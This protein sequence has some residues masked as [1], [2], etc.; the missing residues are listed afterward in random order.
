[1]ALNS[2]VKLGPY[3]IQTPLG[4]GGMGEVYRA[5]D[6]RLDRTVA[7]KILAAQHSSSPELKQRMEREARAISSLN[8]PN[9]CHLYDIGSQDGTDFL[10]MEFLEG[11]TLAERLRA[12]ALALPEVYKI[13]IAVAEA[14]AFA[15]RNG[16]LHRDLKPG[17]IMLTA[18]GAK[19][20]DFGLAKP[21]SVPGAGS[22]SGSAPP[23]FTAAATMSGASPLTPLTTAGTIIGTV[24]YMAP[25]Q[26]EGKEADVR[27]DIFAFGAVLYEMA[28]GKRPFHGKSQLSLA[29]SILESDPEPISTLKPQAPA[30]FDHIV[31][32]CLQKNPEDRFQTAHD[33]KLQLQWV[34]TARPVSG[35]AAADE[36]PSAVAA[37]TPAPARRPLAWMAAVIAGLLLGAMAGFLLH[38]PAPAASVRSVIN[39]PEKSRIN[40]TGDNAGPP[41]VSPDG[42]AI[43]FA[44]A[45]V[46]GKTT[47]WV[48]PTNSLDARPLPDTEGGIFPFWSFDSRSVAFFAEGKMKV[49]EVSGGS[50]QVI[51]DAAFGRGGTWGA[52]GV[53]VYSPATQDRLY[54]IS[55][56]GGTP[57]PITTL[58][59]A[60]HTSH[61][62]PFFLPDGKHFLYL[63]INH[64]S[65][66]SGNDT[67]YYASVDGSVN[68]PLFKSKAN[69]IYADGYLLF[70]RNEQLLAQP[71]NPSSGTLSGE[72]Q[73]LA[74]DVANDPTT[75]HMD[76]AAANG[77]LLVY[78]TGGGNYGT[79]ELLWMDRATKKL[80][81]IVEG[82]PE[83]N[84]FSLSPQGDRIAMQ[85]NNGVSDVWVLDLVRGTR[86]RL[87]F[88]P[89]YNNAPRWSPDGKWIAYTSNRNG[90]FQLFRK[91]SDGGGAEE[92][93]FSDDQLMFPSDWSRDGKYILYDRGLPGT[94]DIWA[95]PLE[96]DRKP[97]QVLP[98]TPNT[99]RASP[100]LSPDGRWL[101]YTSNESGSIQTY[102][103]AFKGG[104]GKWQVSSNTAQ[105]PDWSRD[106]KEL[107]YVDGANSIYAVPVK[108]VAG[109][110][111][112]GTPQ[113]MVSSSSWSSPYPLFQ[114]SQDGKKILLYR[115]SQQ[116]SDAVT[117]VT[118]FASALKK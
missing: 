99:F 39:P 62:W 89:I 59:S 10:V 2:G 115:V 26:I 7:I 24:Q 49:V 45:G 106:G 108:E 105:S 37:A 114:V 13:G 35:K 102:V 38:R 23:S 6:T 82:L 21:L 11:Q 36:S 97:F 27:S 100:R 54:R 19:L 81:M 28:T 84:D 110:L 5:R 25:E 104:S 107:Y 86:T 61:R 90:R 1:M 46:D 31:T 42:S 113:V 96:G 117:V 16:I 30:A 20:M 41:I 66:K 85:M 60:Q 17:N 52:D 9:I 53:I 91:P 68:R 15:H 12:G 83:V 98:T 51:A 78:G 109:A 56:N 22:G 75:W 48:R 93:L 14:L 63:A 3:E 8:H 70:A 50:A 69:A 65:A 67:V 95:L 118:N 72:P 47:I 92:E 112:F 40:L 32:S 74:K 29:S 44:A 58:D 33:I 71:F 34:A 55:V 43:A 77:G 80:S 4:A 94:Q 87:T 76:V 57:T 103:T 88:G 116:V 79:E 73:T 64:D 101:I 111:Q 18:A